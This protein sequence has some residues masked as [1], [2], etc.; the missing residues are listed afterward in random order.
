[1]NGF[2]LTGITR[3]SVAIGLGVLLAL[4]GCDDNRDMDAGTDAST[5]DGGGADGGGMDAG[6]DAGGGDA[7][8]VDAG[9]VDAGD[10]DAGDVGD[11]G[12]VDAGDVDAGGVD[13]G[14]MDGGT[15]T[16]TDYV[17]FRGDFATDGLENVGR[18]DVAT[19]TPVSLAP[20]GLTDA[21]TIRA[22]AISPDGTRL[23]VAGTMTSGGNQVINVYAADGSGAP[24]TVFT[25]A[26]VD[27]NV[28]SLQF[29]PDSMR[30]AWTGAFETTG[31]WDSND[32]ALY[33][34]LA[35][36]T[37]TPIRLSQ[38]VS[39]ANMI[40][41]AFTWID[42]THVAF[43]GDTETQNIDSVW[44][45][46][47]T[48]PATIVE[49]VPATER[50]TFT[51]GQDINGD[52]VAVDAMGRVYFKG[53]FV[54]NGVFRLYR[55]NA[56]GTGF[57]Q[58]AG[59]MLMRGAEEASTLTFGISADG[60]TLAFAANAT[61][62]NVNEIFVMALSGSTA[63]RVDSFTSVDGSFGQGPNDTG[64][65]VF[66][67]DGAHIAFVA[68]YALA[69]GDVNNSYSVYIVPTTGTGGLR[70]FGAPTDAALD[71]VQ[72]GW[73]PDSAW[74]LARA[75]FNL[76]GEGELFGTMNLTSA[77]QAVSGLTLVDAPTGGD[78]YELEVASIP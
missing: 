76:D 22:F 42:D 21:F 1:M 4:T 47:A 74:L 25:A 37:G 44:S 48:A 63:A 68:D 75:D 77:D 45:V 29:S 43:M 40:V 24:T 53:D 32:E 49:L 16:T 19:M 12:D 11:A 38:T 14:D 51:T 31:M 39:A 20:S 27:R 36:G 26:A 60:G 30:L 28:V 35:D 57:E 73:S 6:R 34:T 33:A 5:A 64:L 58:V 23:A 15:P 70:L 10:V 9:D 71:A 66:S 54:T 78:V 8:D 72:V 13:A 41:N 46:D 62:T 67:P 2:D 55:N 50:A 69:T 56:T 18:M 17:Y 59:T 3:P 7:G 65:L 61:T 52:L